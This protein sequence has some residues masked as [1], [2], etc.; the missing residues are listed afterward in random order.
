LLPAC[1]THYNSANSFANYLFKTRKD[2]ILLQ[3]FISAKTTTVTTGGGV[4]VIDSLLEDVI[5][6]EAERFKLRLGG[7][8]EGVIEKHQNSSFFMVNGEPIY[9][10][11]RLFDDEKRFDK[12]TANLLLH[13]IRADYHHYFDFWNLGIDDRTK[14]L[15]VPQ[16]NFG[17]AMMGH[18][19]FSEYGGF[20]DISIGLIVAALG[21]D[22]VKFKQ[23]RQKKIDDVYEW[24]DSA[25]KSDSEM[26]S[27]VNKEGEPLLG[28]YLF[29]VLPLERKQV[30]AGMVLAGRMDSAHWRQKTV[31]H[32]QRTFDLEPFVMGYGTCY[33]VN[34]NVLY[35]CNLDSIFLSTVAHDEAKIE[36]YKKMGLIAGKDEANGKFVESLYIRN[37]EGAGISDDMAFIS[38]AGQEYLAKRHGESGMWGAFV[39]DGIDTYDKY[40][41]NICEG[42]QDEHLANHI[43]QK[44]KA[45]YNEDLV[46]DKETMEIIYTS[47]KG[48]SPK[49][50]LSDSHRRFVQY[51]DIP[52]MST[53]EMH[54]EFVSGNPISGGTFG[55]N[56]VKSQSFY[57]KAQL[58]LERIEKYNNKYGRL[59]RLAA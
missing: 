20:S 22:P 38:I 48:N 17:H 33:P 28:Y 34:L 45:K 27:L 58:R 56:P 35:D 10:P 51:Q 40:A 14:E 53:I 43:A 50:K 25:I 4:V 6:E 37:A 42:G 15:L 59:E 54:Q 9:V 32:Y 23:L 7:M 3:L 36:E 57:Q 16:S 5:S 19:T 18:C 30:L 21:W 1:I 52:H 44:W 49:I 13:L 8:Q 2:Y 47:A 12:D 29:R 26:T 39:V 11:N 41:V 31:E 24:A 55:F 46:T